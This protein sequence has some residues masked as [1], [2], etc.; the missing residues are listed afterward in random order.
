L[1]RTA[2]RA[3]A[4]GVLTLVNARIALTC[5]IA[6]SFFSQ[7]CSERPGPCGCV[8]LDVAVR[9]LEN[10]NT[11]DWRQIDRSAL[12]ADW[13]Q[14]VPCEAGSEG[15]LKGAAEQIA[16]C[17]ERC[18]MCGSAAMDE[19]PTQAGL[20]IVE[21]WICPR[22]LES[23]RGALQ[24]LTQ[25]V[26]GSKPDP[27]PTS[28]DRGDARIIEGYSWVSG[29]E[30]FMLRTDAIRTDDDWMGN[31]QLGRCR[32]EDVT[33][34]WRVDGDDSVRV[35]RADVERSTTDDSELRFEYVTTCL[36]E[37]R[38]CHASELD[39]LWP[40][41][42]SRAGQQRVTAIH[43]SAEN[44][45]GSSISFRLDR[46]ADGQWKGGVWSPKGN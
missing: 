17:C 24:R 36:I 40:T 28:A 19:G 43:L 23:Q 8:S 12:E 2:L 10:L 45:V 46:G 35:I 11:R 33:D 22:P 37:D 6:L 44:C 18:E 16:R 15:G 34:T 27:K 32:S 38:S 5:V 20:R 29:G 42:R 7:S 41:L 21:L 25:A 3:A 9:G 13:P 31:F 14:A 39:Q 30:L 26:V 1:Q 4:E